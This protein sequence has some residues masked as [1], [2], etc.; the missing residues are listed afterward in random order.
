MTKFAMALLP[1]TLVLFV[2]Q[3]TKP[4]A[5]LGRPDHQRIADGAKVFADNCA[6]CHGEGV[7]WTESGCRPESLAGAPDRFEKEQVMNL[8]DH[9]VMQMPS[10]ADMPQGERDLLWDYLSDL[11]TD[12]NAG[13]T[14]GQ[15]CGRVQAA[16]AGKPMAGGC[17]GGGAGLG[18]QR[19]RKGWSFGR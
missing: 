1:L 7:E 11:P 4:F 2:S 18:P 16:M 12:P 10:F 13:P 17:G 15:S 3:V 19:Q 5:Q 8:L 14:R 6:R 9:G